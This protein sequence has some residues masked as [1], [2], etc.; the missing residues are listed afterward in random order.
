M[1]V[2]VLGSGVGFPIQDQVGP[3]SAPIRFPK[4]A[5]F[6]LY[7]LQTPRQQRLETDSS[8]NWTKHFFFKNVSGDLPTHDHTRPPETATFETFARENEG[9]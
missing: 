1:W 2:P 6:G 7:G 5:S 8:Q 9:F 4:F 3:A